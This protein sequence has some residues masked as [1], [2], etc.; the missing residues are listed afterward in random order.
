MVT[1][2]IKQVCPTN[3]CKTAP[4]FES[5]KIIVLSLPP[6]AIILPSGLNATERT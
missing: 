1:D 4:V 6:D 3:L 5:H 2:R